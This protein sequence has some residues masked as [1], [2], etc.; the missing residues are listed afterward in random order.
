M[1]SEPLTVKGHWTEQLWRDM[2]WFTCGSNNTK[3]IQSAFFSHNTDASMSEP[4]VVSKQRLVRVSLSQRYYGNHA[5]HSRVS[6]L[7]GHAYTTWKQAICQL[8]V[9]QCWTWGQQAPPTFLNA[10]WDQRAPVLPVWNARA[11]GSLI[12]VFIHNQWSEP[13]THYSF[14]NNYKVPNIAVPQITP[15][16]CRQTGAWKVLFYT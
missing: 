14:Q 16:G 13:S 6:L 8:K 4:D 3:P 7:E 12:P 9:L 5:G 2:T 1:E 15:R 11:E 10:L